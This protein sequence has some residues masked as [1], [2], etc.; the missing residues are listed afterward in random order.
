MALR[1]AIGKLGYGGL[2]M[3][4]W[5]EGKGLPMN[6]YPPIHFVASSS[7]AF[8]SHPI[9]V[10]FV[11]VVAGFAIVGDSPAGLW[12]ITPIS[13]L[14]VMSLVIGYEGPK[15]RERFGAPK[16]SPLFGVPLSTEDMPPLG[17]RFAAGLMAFGPWVLG[18][19][20]LSCM[21]TPQNPAQLRLAYELTL[22]RPEWAIWLYSAAYPLVAVSPLYIRSL[23]DLRRLVLGARLATGVG[24]FLMLMLP[25]HSAF[26]PVD[27]SAAGTWLA[28]ANRTMDADWLAFP[29]FHALWA[30][31]VAQAM[32]RSVPRLRMAWW[33][34]AFG[35]SG[36]CVL[37]GSH[38]IV[39]VLA[40][41]GLGVLCW[42]YD[43]VWRA[44]VYC[45]ERLGNSWSALEL[46]PLR[47]ISHAIW[48]FAA[49]ATGLILVL[50][51]AG[52]GT[53]FPC[54]IVVVTGLL[55]AGVWGYWLEGGARLSR[56]FGYYGFLL[57][58]LGALGALAFSGVP[59]AGALTAAFAAG[60]SLAQAF[61]RLR[62]VVQGCC[63]GRQAPAVSGIRVVHRVSRVAAHANLQ[64]VPIHPTQLY[65]IVGNLVLAGVLLRLWSTHAPWTVI[66]GLYLVLSSLAR[67]AEEQYRGE[68]QTTK[69]GGL[70][71][72]QWL[73][74]AFFLAGAALTMVPGPLVSAA[75]WWSP[76]GLA[77]S[78][79][80]GLVAAFL[81]SVDFPRSERRFSRST[82]S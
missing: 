27:Y 32:S 23:A 64:G 12:V 68:P 43:R 35:I 34:L 51:L 82:V 29:A 55:S 28:D 50:Y 16:K 25:G 54:G 62:C 24:F 80:A 42:Q 69:W 44:L 60:A 73:A 14:A 3:A 76:G 75:R 78:V 1:E 4:L 19:S 81:L 21:P 77:F 41:I 72:Y 56:P 8:L 45:S 5:R 33:A 37:T 63:H 67:F 38:A 36:S 53:I 71:V 26:L 52:P 47:I 7:Y 20:L 18:Y 10:A 59:E 30:V 57:G 2:F 9:Y 58:G 49:A 31:F 11:A 74:V 13:A 15:L 39:D 6:A 79:G 70:A 22:A 48:S 61:G 46:G 40:G 66:G 65:S 17:R